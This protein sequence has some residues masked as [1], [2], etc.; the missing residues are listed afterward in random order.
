MRTIGMFGCGNIA[1]LLVPRL[2]SARVT[3][4]FDLLPERAAALADR[5]GA[6]S[7]DSFEDF[8][9]QDFDVLVEAASVAGV[10]EKAAAALRAG[11]DLVIMSVGALM[12]PLLREELLAL[13][14][15]V[16]RRVQVPSGAIAGLDL[17]HIGRVSR[18]DRVLL[19]TT[20]QPRSLGLGEGERGLVFSGPAS[21]CV[22]RFPRNV[23]VAAALSL[24]SGRDVEVEVWAD[25]DCPVNR[26][27][28]I[29]EGEFGRS[30]LTLENLPS[31]DNPRTSQLAAL[32]LAALLEQ[33]EAPLI[34][35]T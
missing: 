2:Q 28:V 21:D 20:K 16:G 3:A 25:P 9:R 19:K 22:D 6:R 15:E 24:A 29:V 30:V 33:F 35:G 10:H 13:G 18:L 14:R 8:I 12:D 23:N 4:C 17:L 11:K 5:C 32:S 26:H 31:P 34:I 7:F 1:G 27:E